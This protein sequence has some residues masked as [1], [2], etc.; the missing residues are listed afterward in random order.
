MRFLDTTESRETSRELM[1]AILKVANGDEQEAV[2]IWED[3]TE[4]E[5]V[6]IVE[7]VTNNGL[8]GEPWDYCWGDSGAEWSLLY[9]ETIEGADQAI[10][11][12]RRDGARW[13]LCSYSDPTEDGR[14]GI[15]IEEAERIGSEDPSLIYARRGE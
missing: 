2:R 13:I 8:R 15:S 1:E 14:E 4:A 3:P 7:S 5:I 10:A 6:A 12:V 9:V 11:A